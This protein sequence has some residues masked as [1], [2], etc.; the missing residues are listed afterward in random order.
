MYSC[1]MALRTFS[2]TFEENLFKLKQVVL[3]LRNLEK[4]LFKLE[5]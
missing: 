1:S 5:N 4:A 2:F 3:C